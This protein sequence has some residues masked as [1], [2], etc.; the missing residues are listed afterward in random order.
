MNSEH[1]G[2]SLDGVARAGRPQG[3]WYLGPQG[4]WYLG[5]QDQGVLVVVQEGC[6][7]WGAVVD[8]DLKAGH[9]AH[10][11]A[12]H[13]VLQELHLDQHAAAALHPVAR[14][15]PASQVTNSDIFL[16]MELHQGDRLKGQR[17]PTGHQL[18]KHC[19][20]NHLKYQGLTVQYPLPLQC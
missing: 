16:C 13:P 12:L 10:P 4:V 6:P 1:P 17:R 20:I 19:F 3:V 9:G 5:R 14:G 8:G 2:R 7:A 11:P 18:G 15:G